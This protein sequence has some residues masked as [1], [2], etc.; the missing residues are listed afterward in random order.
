MAES[1]RHKARSRRSGIL[2]KGRDGSG[3][4]DVPA[5]GYY[6]IWDSEYGKKHGQSLDRPISASM[7]RLRSH[8]PLV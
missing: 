6:K 2:I 5:G 1:Q 7:C 8:K 4:H 3:E